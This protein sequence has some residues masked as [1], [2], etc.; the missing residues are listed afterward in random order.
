MA[1]KLLILLF[2]LLAASC[3]PGENGLPSG[4]AT[5]ELRA[6][7]DPDGNLLISDILRSEERR[8]GK[9]CRFRR[10]T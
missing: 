4:P 9:E 8:V 6:F 7:E 3:S 10:A 1:K 2:L 5:G